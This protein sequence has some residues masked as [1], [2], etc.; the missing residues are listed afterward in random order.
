MIAPTPSV[1]RLL[2]DLR[3]ATLNLNVNIEV[4]SHMVLTRLQYRET[5]SISKKKRKGSETV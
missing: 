4:K 2:E 5:L 3:K 1:V